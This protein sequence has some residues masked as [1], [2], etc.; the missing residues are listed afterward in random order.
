MAVNQS[1]DDVTKRAADNHGC[2]D[3]ARK[4]ELVAQDGAGE[5]GADDQCQP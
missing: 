1:V 5:I 2:T 3:F 4:T